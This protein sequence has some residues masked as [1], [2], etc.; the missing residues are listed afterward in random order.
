[1][2]KPV[3][4]GSMVRK[5][6]NP[7]SHESND[8]NDARNQTTDMTDMTSMTAPTRSAF[9]RGA[10]G[11]SCQEPLMPPCARPHAPPLGTAR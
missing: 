10:Q 5:S 4:H 2:T 3:A 8:I 6:F 11:I 9:K 1:M 7:A